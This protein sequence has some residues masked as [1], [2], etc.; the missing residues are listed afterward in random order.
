M[1]HHQVSNKCNRVKGQHWR[2]LI[3]APHNF[4][5]CNNMSKIILVLSFVCFNCFNP[6]FVVIH[7]QVVNQSTFYWS[8]YVRHVH[9]WFM[10]TLRKKH[11]LHSKH[12]CIYRSQT[13]WSFMKFYFVHI[14]K[15]CFVKKQSLCLY[16]S[17]YAKNTPNIRKW[18]K[19][20]AS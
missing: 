15:V 9:I 11:S 4:L 5:L 13:F 18:E 14:V 6:I 2:W 1:S 10:K 12:T 8:A 20:I 17:V 3:Y 19:T 7:E 16:S